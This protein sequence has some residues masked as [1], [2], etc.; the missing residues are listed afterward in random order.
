MTST[1]RFLHPLLQLKLAIDHSTLSRHSHNTLGHNDRP[2]PLHTMGDSP[3]TLATT[4]TSA[5]PPRHTL[6]VV[7]PNSTA[8]MTSALHLPVRRVLHPSTRA[9]FLTG[10]SPGAPASINDEVDARASASAC[11]PL[12]RAEM[13]RADA[14]LVACYSRHPL[15]GM[16]AA[17]WAREKAAE[18]KVA[19]GI[20]EASVGLALQ[21]CGA[22][23]A[24]RFGIVST[25]RQWEG[26]LAGAVEDLL[27]LGEGGAAGGEAGR[28]AGV[29]T[30]G[31]TA[32]ELHETPAE[33]V[34]RRVR[35]AVGRL[36][37]REGVAVVCLGCAGMAGMEEWVREGC[38]EARGEVEGR[39]VRIVDGVMAGVALLEGALL[40]G[41]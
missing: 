22:A 17:E 6:L 16:V 30:T 19:T 20:F 27:G 10:P 36:L 2:N 21:L 15:V 18:G 11:W 7:N 24:G 12:V 8:A 25:G 9:H 34:R 4:S 41:V 5:S 29:E 35:A 14:V 3:P 1:K 33:E 28:F 38:V 40:A 31:L 26:I 32:V 23:P 13:A 37:A 39:K